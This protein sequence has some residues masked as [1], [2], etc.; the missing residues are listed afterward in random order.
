VLLRCPAEHLARKKPAACDGGGLDSSR[1][2]FLSDFIQNHQDQAGW[3]AE[4]KTSSA[5]EMDHFVVLGF[6]RQIPEEN[7]GKFCLAH[8]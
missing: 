5:L 7:Y 6:V 3:I 2:V 4:R 1:C 8:F